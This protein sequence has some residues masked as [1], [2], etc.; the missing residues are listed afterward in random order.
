MLLLLWIAILAVSMTVLIKASD[1]FTNSA[2]KIGIYLGIPMFVI[3]ITIVSIGTSLPEF[4]TS[5]VAAFVG[6]PEIVI[7]NV[8]GSNITNIL[9]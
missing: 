7:G 4:L 3:G 9:L 1:M 2:E 8:I 5:M 6:S